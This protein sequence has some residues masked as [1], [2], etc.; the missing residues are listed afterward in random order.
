MPDW[1]GEFLYDKDRVLGNIEQLQYG[2]YAR[3][4]EQPKWCATKEEAIAWVEEKDAGVK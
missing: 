2:W 4:A 3:R 1:I